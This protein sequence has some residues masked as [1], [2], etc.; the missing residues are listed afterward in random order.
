MVSIG[1][2]KRARNDGAFCGDAYG[3]WHGHGKT[4]IC[5]IDGLGH[6][7]PAAT[8]ASAA[9]DYIG[10]RA[11]LPLAELFTGCNKTLRGTRGAAMGLA[12]ID[13]CPGNLT[14][15]GVGNTRAM[16]CGARTARLVSSHGIVGAGYRNL[17]MEEV[18]LLRGDL[19]ILTTDGIRADLDLAAYPLKL[20]GDPQA[21]AESIVHEWRHE[22][23]DDAAVLV[24]QYTGA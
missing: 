21:L 10:G 17:L 14:F 13:E 23:P 12:V 20:R 11:F 24:F 1:V 16:V 15:A 19:V 22:P 18:S 8:A 3:H 6:G 5:I 7:Q 2:I 9:I 4:T